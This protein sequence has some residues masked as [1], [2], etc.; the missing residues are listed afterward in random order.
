MKLPSYDEPVLTPVF[1][2]VATQG[3]LKGLSVAQLEAIEPSLR[4]ILNNT[5][6]TAFSEPSSRPQLFSKLQRADLSAQQYHLSQRPTAELLD[7]TGGSHQYQGWRRNLLTD[8]GGFQ[9]VSLSVRC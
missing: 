9:M 3:T 2:P 8:S 7:L 6:R 1:M 4:L 5:V